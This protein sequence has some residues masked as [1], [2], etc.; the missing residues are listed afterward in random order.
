MDGSKKN[1]FTRSITTHTHTHTHTNTMIITASLITLTR[2]KTTFSISKKSITN[3]ASQHTHYTHTHTYKH[4]HTHTR[5]LLHQVWSDKCKKDLMTRITKI[6]TQIKITKTQL[7][8][9]KIANTNSRRTR[10]RGC[11]NCFTTTYTTL[12]CLQIIDFRSPSVAVW[13]AECGSVCVAECVAAICCTTAYT[14]YE[15][16]SS[17]NSHTHPLQTVNENPT[18]R[19]KEP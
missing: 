9:Q 5:G 1:D 18:D 8:I 2:M 16:Q 10:R 4:K 15:F 11:S 17:Y 14:T 12:N 19:A 13:V 6:K 7:K 3:A